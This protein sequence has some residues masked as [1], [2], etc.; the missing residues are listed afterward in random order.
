[1]I[2]A[3]IEAITG[4]DKNNREIE[5]ARKLGIKAKNAEDLDRKVARAEREETSG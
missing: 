2:M 5:K 1:M 3:V 4:T